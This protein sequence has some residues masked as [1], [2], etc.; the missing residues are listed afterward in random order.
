M[1]EFALVLLGC[2]AFGMPV[3][4]DAVSRFLT[5][6]VNSY[7]TRQGDSLVSIAARYGLEPAALAADNRIRAAT[8]LRSGQVLR[9]DS[10]HIAPDGLNEGI[11]IN[12]AQRMLFVAHDS[13]ILGA[14]PVAVGR[15][16]WPSPLGTFEIGTKE[17]DPTWEVPVSI[18]REMKRE[19]RPVLTVVAPGPDNPLG[20][21]WLGLQAISV[22]IHG[23][24]VPSSIFRW[25]T[26]G[27]I[28]LH[29]DDARELFDMVE[30]GS[31]VHIV[32]EPVLLAVDAEGKIWLEVNR[33]P[34]RRVADLAQLTREL[35]ENAGLAPRVDDAAVRKCIQERRGR[36][37]SV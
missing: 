11:H 26:H 36:P 12:V 13:R 29:P 10:R 16:D 15:Q 31:P 18:Q 27:C 22:G 20:D 24:N 17:I 14:Y 9:V 2:I 5:G 23:T 1:R 3:S 6:S 4:G 30:V 19:G 7:T 32:Y 34:Y 8:P 35:L 33:D 21:R 37:C 28:R 25:T